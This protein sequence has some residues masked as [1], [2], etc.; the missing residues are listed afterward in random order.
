M[1]SYKEV[2]SF[3]RTEKL[4]DLSLMKS[5]LEALAAQR[6]VLQKNRSVFVG[7]SFALRFSEVRGATTSF[8]NVVLSLSALSKYDDQPFIVA[9]VRVDQVE[10]RLANT[11]FLKKISHSS[12]T[13]SLSNIKGSFL[14]HDIMASYGGIDNIPENFDALF[15]LHKKIGWDD[16]LKRLVSATSQIEATGSKFLPDSV[17]LANIYNNPHRSAVVLQDCQFQLAKKGLLQKIENL[18][19]QILIA[20]NDTNINTRGNTIEQLITQSINKHGA[21]DI[22]LN[23][24][25]DIYL[26]I[27]IK[28]KIAGLSSNPKAFNVDKLLREL[29]SLGNYVFFLFVLIDLE[30]G[31]VK[32]NLLSVF[33]EVLIQYTRVQHHWAG[34]NS[35]GA[36]QL[37]ADITDLVE[38]S[39]EDKIN[40]DS[41]K[42]FLDKLLS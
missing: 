17:A 15:A 26:K 13:L 38:Q 30:R 6:F 14:G 16:N 29:S 36:T 10:F 28:T 35:R 27:D 41:A 20:A 1:S 37:N 21:E 12:H 9:I 18:K 39:Y 8:S 4:K 34:R 2:V 42:A 31:V 24:K 3:L 33:N 23:L 22:V 25:E 40:Q 11:S 5:R 7:S 32:A 19:N